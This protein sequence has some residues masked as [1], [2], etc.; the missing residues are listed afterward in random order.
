MIS[1]GSATERT[2]CGQ[3][4]VNFGRVGSNRLK[5][6]CSITDGKNKVRG[7]IALTSY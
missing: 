1:L 6:K 3:L 5:Q 7:L 4:I 2:S